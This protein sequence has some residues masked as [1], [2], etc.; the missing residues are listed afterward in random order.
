MAKKQSFADKSSKK[1][2]SLG[3]FVKYVKSIL[4]EKSGH[5]R[6]NE[7]IVNIKDGE[8]LDSALK[9]INEETHALDIEMPTDNVEA[10][11]PAEEEAPTEEEAP[12]EEEADNK[13]DKDS[14]SISNKS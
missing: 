14:D 4:S 7:Q 11:A 1:G 2:K 9:R 10:E 6:F 12:A 3:S 5:W 8:N 13:K